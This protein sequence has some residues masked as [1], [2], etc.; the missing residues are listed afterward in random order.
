MAMTR[1]QKGKMKRQEIYFFIVNYI[2]VHGYAPSY[3]EIGEG[4]N[5]KSTSTVNMHMTKMFTEGML[6][7][8]VDAFMDGTPGIV[9]SRA[10]RVPGYKFVKE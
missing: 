10:I 3:R 1:T 4:V 6:E 5:L 7:T 8:D 9:S 2:K